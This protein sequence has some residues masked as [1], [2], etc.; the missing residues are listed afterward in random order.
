MHTVTSHLS[1][2]CR[3]F[4]ASATLVIVTAALA[5]LHVGTPAAR[6]ADPPSGPNYTRADL[7]NPT[8]TRAIRISYRSHTGAMRPA[9][10]LVPRWYGPDRHPLIPL[11]IAPHGRGVPHTVNAHRW[12]NLPGIGGFALVSPGGQGNHLDK[13]SWGAKGQIRDLARMPDIV[14]A[15]LPWLRVDRTRIYAFGGSMGGQETLL[16]AA[17]HP[18]LLAGAAAVDSLVDFPRQYRNFPRLGCK[19]ACRRN[20]DGSIGLAMQKLARREVG[21]T[22]QTAPAGYALRSPLNYARAIGASCVPL[23]IWWSRKDRIV[24]DSS[25]QSGS[26]FKRIKSA[27]RRA[28]LTGYVGS[29]KHAKA[30]K[31]SRMLPYALAKF[32]LMPAV[33][34]EKLTGAKSIAA[35][36]NACSR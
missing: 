33:F 10:V 12:G 18:S 28:P 20:W 22:P 2:R 5:A 16:L 7:E 34:S 19:A 17:Q 36:A 4:R 32:G 29:W 9:I 24:V 26:L 30:F 35:P 15:R 6:S 8:E 27:N 11:V 23:Q 3:P 21:G 14:K 25:K 31:P 1:R 13:Y